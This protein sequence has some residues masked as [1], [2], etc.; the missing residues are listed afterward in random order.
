MVW[1]NFS[2]VK[3]A[4]IYFYITVW[5]NEKFSLIEKKIRQINYL[6]ISV[7]KRT[8][9]FTKFLRKKRENFCNFHTMNY[10]FLAKISWKRCFIKEIT[11]IDLTKYFLL[12]VRVNFTFSHT[13]LSG[14]YVF[15]LSLEINREKKIHSLI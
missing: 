12:Y 10:T 13:V 6:V 11:R 15:L 1:R 4:E 5:K 2:T 3:I 14:D 7:V 8:I 9:A